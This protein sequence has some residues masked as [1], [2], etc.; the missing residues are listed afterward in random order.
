MTYSD[1]QP[2]PDTENQIKVMRYVL[3]KMINA[4]AVAI[5]IGIQSHAP[6]ALYPKAIYCNDL[7]TLPRMVTQLLEQELKRK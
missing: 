2:A 5:G 6:E 7:R 3:G 1:G 4:G